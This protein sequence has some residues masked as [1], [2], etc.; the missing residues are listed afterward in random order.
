[1]N[2]LCHDDSNINIILVITVINLLLLGRITSINRN[3]MPFL[4]SIRQ[5]SGEFSIFRQDSALSHWALEAVNSLTMTL[6]NV[7]Q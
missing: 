7:E 5:I 6:P 1:M 2:R 4:P 3:L